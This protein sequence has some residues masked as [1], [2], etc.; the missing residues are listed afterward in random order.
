MDEKQFEIICKK[1][2][3]IAI[4]LTIQNIDDKDKKVSILKRAGFDSTEIGELLGIQ[5]V[6]QMKGWKKND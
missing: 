4:A 3:K 5:N 2:D 1:L 6:C